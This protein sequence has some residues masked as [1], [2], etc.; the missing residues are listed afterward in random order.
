MKN[1]PPQ[2]WILLVGLLAVSS[3]CG[4]PGT[5]ALASRQPAAQPAAAVPPLSA[6]QRD[7]LQLAFDAASA[8]PTEPHGKNRSRAQE[9]VVVAC[10]ELG[11]PDLAVAYG[12]RIT[13]WRRGCAYADYAWSL[14]RRGET[15]R[16]L[17]YVGLANGVAA[18]EKED[19]TAQ[20]WRRDLI[21]WKV[22]R[23]H[24]ALGDAAAAAEATAGIDPAST[25]AVDGGWAATAA[26][27]VACATADAA[28]AE[29][30]AI[31]AGFAAMSLGQ[32]NVAMTTLARLHEQFFAERE[33]REACE[34]RI[35]VTWAKTMPALRLA[36][37]AQMVRTNRAHGETAAAK[38][39][40]ATM[41]GIVESHRWRP[42]DRLP[43]VAQ[44]IELACEV[45]ENDRARADAEAALAAYHQERETIVDIYRAETLRPLALAWFALGEPD[46]GQELLALV[47]EEGM[48]NPNSRPR[49]DDLVD[50]C[51]A[52]AKRGIEP[53]A[54]L[55]ARLREIQRGLGNP[56]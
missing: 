22:A 30:A 32:Q 33:L 51:T 13:D 2:S 16:A 7:L 35:A 11:Q 9:Q 34:Q 21:A 6:F 31:D 39:L 8:F 17:E 25:H 26:D 15:S 42:E 44:L 29:F 49:C 48:E 50:T 53:S 24:T 27:R 12:T 10:F 18:A 20:E 43:Q 47:L 36:A 54:A 3:S 45:G 41:R 5:A 4:G 14:A 55:W 56:W 37:L 28:A 46:R 38:S 40:L 52:L 23:V 19:A 1:F